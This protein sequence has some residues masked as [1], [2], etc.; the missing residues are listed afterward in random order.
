M[1][2]S[3]RPGYNKHSHALQQLTATLRHAAQRPHHSSVSERDNAYGY[4]LHCQFTLDKQLNRHRRECHSTVNCSRVCY[5]C[6]V[7]QDSE[8]GNYQRGKSDSIR[9]STVGHVL[10][11]ISEVEVQ[12]K[13]MRNGSADS[14]DSLFV[15][16]LYHVF[17]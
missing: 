15:F 6:C 2:N 16:I 13:Q 11:L 7:P 8:S 3:T 12:C 9:V 17:K 5:Y 4:V 14:C 1:D 10:R